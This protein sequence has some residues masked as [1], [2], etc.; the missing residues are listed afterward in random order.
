MTIERGL[1]MTDSPPP[2]RTSLKYTNRLMPFS[3]SQSRKALDSQV[4]PWTFSSLPGLPATVNREKLI[5]K[6]FFDINVFMGQLELFRKA[7][8]SRW[9]RRKFGRIYQRFWFAR[10]CGS[11]RLQSE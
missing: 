7:R 4:R 1:Q 8:Y 3:F 2:D 6:Y 10:C 5:K 9:D 11:R